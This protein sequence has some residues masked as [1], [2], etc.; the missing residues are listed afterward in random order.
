MLQVLR[1]TLLVLL[2]LAILRIVTG[3]LGYEVCL[4]SCE[5]R[6]NGIHFQITI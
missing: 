6:L 3:P 4:E 5:D 1:Y 2:A